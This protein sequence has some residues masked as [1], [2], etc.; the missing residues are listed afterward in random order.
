MSALRDSESTRQRILEITAEEMVKK[1]YQG[2]ALSDIISRAG[3]S[4]GAL[5]YHFKNKSDLGYAV[6]EEIFVEMHLQKWYQALC[7]KD[8]IGGLIAFIERETNLLTP[9]TMAQGCP[10]NTISQEMCGVDEGFRVRVSSMFQ[11]QAEMIEKEFGRAR[12]AGI[13][14]DGLDIP[15]I[16]QYIIASFQGYACLTKSGCS[17]ENVMMWRRAQISYLESLRA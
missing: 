11:R 6:F 16:V 3:M 15:A 12:D 2:V 13:I 7:V 8:P 4:K 17:M 10:V 14:K 1:G 5:Y 9:E